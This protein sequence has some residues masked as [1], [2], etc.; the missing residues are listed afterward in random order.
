ML[1]HR[2]ETLRRIVGGDAHIA[3]SILLS[4][5]GMIAE[6]YINN[7]YIKHENANV[8]KYVIMSN[9]IYMIIALENGAMW[10]SPPT[11]GMAIARRWDIPL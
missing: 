1:L 3:P 7:I 11:D 8:D 5:I 9:H 2:C 10:A 6:K 4:E